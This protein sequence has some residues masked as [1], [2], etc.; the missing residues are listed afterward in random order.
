MKGLVGGLNRRG[1]REQVKER[2]EESE[3]EQQER[4][5]ERERER[6][7]RR[8]REMESESHLPLFLFSLQEMVGLP[9]NLGPSSERR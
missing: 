1:K 5:Q 3:S 6:E 4:E 2:L 7:R 8:Q 9:Q